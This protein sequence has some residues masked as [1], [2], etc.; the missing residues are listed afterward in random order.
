MTTYH[1]SSERREDL[2][3]LFTFRDIVAFNA[4]KYI[5]TSRRNYSLTNNT[6]KRSFKAFKMDGLLRKHTDTKIIH[7]NRRWLAGKRKKYKCFNEGG[8]ND[9]IIYNFINSTI[10]DRSSSFGC[11]YW[12]HNIAAGVRRRDYLRIDYYWHR[13]F[14]HKKE[15]RLRP[16]WSLFFLRIFYNL[17]NEGGVTYASAERE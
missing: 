2:L 7:A 9:D 15:K 17:Y 6:R 1:G 4:G 13:T 14:F 10:G 8:M 3:L 11:H 12:W 5:E 16:I